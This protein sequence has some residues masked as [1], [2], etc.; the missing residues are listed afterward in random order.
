MGKGILNHLISRILV[1]EM[2]KI[3]GEILAETK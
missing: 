2:K 3:I 1:G